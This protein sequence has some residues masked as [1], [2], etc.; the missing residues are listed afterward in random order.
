MLG[1]VPLGR[2]S[3]RTG[4]PL[5]RTRDQKP[6]TSDQGYPLWTD[7]QTPVKTLPSPFLW[8]AGGKKQIVNYLD[9]SAPVQR[10]NVFVEI[11]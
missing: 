3:E 10:M 9:S 2:T 6:W 7:R 8:N 4:F 1:W 11:V 5:E